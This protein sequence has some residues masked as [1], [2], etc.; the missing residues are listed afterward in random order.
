MTRELFGANKSLT[1]AGLEFMLELAAITQ[2]AHDRGASAEEEIA[3]I[4]QHIAKQKDPARLILAMD[5]VIMA[6]QCVLHIQ[7]AITHMLDGEGV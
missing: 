6:A 3:L 1:G 7:I 4:M 2:T 5:Q